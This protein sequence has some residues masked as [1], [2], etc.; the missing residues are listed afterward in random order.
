MSV[1]DLW[2]SSGRQ[3]HRMPLATANG[4]KCPSFRVCCIR[5]AGAPTC[6]R[7]CIS[8]YVVGVLG[9]KL[10]LGSRCCSPAHH[11]ILLFWHQACLGIKRGEMCF[12]WADLLASSVS[13]TPS[14]ESAVVRSSLKLA[15][16]LSAQTEQRG[17][18]CI[19]GGADDIDIGDSVEAAARS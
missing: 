7:K 5:R 17:A 10:P 4:S 18:N 6:R 19:K 3:G 11:L 13:P 2:E 1:E 9:N 16:D 15:L 14:W 8:R 12:K